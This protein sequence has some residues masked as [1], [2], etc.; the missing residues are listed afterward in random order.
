MSKP[1]DCLRK[2]VEPKKPP[3]AIGDWRTSGNSRVALT[4]IH[5]GGSASIEVP[6]VGLKPASLRELAEFCTELADQLDGK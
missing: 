6:T 3:M 2:Q 4:A 5:F 1:W